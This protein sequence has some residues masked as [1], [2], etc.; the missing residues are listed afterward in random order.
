MVRIWLALVLVIVAG[1]ARA[2]LQS[3]FP[4]GDDN[5][6]SVTR[7]SLFTSNDP[8]EFFAPL[9][10]RE[11]PAP[12]TPVRVAPPTNVGTATKPI[13]QLLALVA[14]AEAGSG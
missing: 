11:T 2:E 8:I 6:N 4:R 3:L 9:P 13:D 1:G 10:D 12:D 14:R 7:A 5:G